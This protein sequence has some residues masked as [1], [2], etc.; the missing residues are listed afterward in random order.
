MEKGNDNESKICPSESE[1]E[2]EEGYS[3]DMDLKKMPSRRWLKD[4]QRKSDKGYSTLDDN[5]GRESEE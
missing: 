2:E 4:A 1:N 5:R 3:L